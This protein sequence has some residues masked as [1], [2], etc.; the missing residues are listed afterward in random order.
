MKSEKDQGFAFKQSILASQGLLSSNDEGV[1]GYQGN[2]GYQPDNATSSH[3][4]THATVGEPLPTCAP[5]APDT[6]NT[7]LAPSPTA[8]PLAP[9]DVLQAPTQR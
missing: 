8:K 6:Q 4:A 3:P 1:V 9:G 2:R 7:E 5:V